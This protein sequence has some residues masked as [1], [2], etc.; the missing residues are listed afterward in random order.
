M[1]EYNSEQKEKKKGNHSECEIKWMVSMVKTKQKTSP[2]FPITH[3]SDLVI[4]CG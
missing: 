1:A 2:K 4:I 3:K